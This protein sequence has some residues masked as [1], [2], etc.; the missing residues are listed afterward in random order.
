MTPNVSVRVFFKG[1]FRSFEYAS[2]VVFTASKE[3]KYT[4]LPQRQHHVFRDPFS[5][6]TKHLNGIVFENELLGNLKTIS[7]EE[8]H[9]ARDVTNLLF[10]YKLTNKS[11]HTQSRV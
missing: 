5:D 2:P 7:R 11:A 8:W 4:T 10:V 9:L 6:I 3:E 1:L